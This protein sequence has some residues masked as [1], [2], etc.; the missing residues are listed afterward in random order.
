WRGARREHSRPKPARRENDNAGGNTKETEM[1]AIYTHK[2]YIEEA[3]Q[4]PC[5][6][7]NRPKELNVATFAAQ[8][9]GGDSRLGANCLGK[10]AK[11]KWRSRAKPAPKPSGNNAP[12]AV[13][14][15]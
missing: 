6:F 8:A 5:D 14:V 12:V 4:Q 3:E 13:P 2:G 11:M 7:C 15:K 10:Q 9:G 1:D